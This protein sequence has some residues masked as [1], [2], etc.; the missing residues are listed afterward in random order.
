MTNHPHR[1]R[2]DAPEPAPESV[3]PM[4]ELPPGLSQ[5]GHGPTAR[6]MEALPQMLFQAV[7][8]ALQQVQVT[9]APLPCATCFLARLQWGAS[10]AAE[11]REAERAYAAAVAEQEQ[12]DPQDRVA[13]DP[14]SFAPDSL[15]S[16][17]PLQGGTVMVGGT[18][19][20][21]QHIPGA[22]GMPGTSPL[23]IAQAH[24]TPGMLS[25]MTRGRAA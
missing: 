3:P 15:Q 5:N 10:H 13:L 22:P 20:C 4:T 9:T 18:L 21:A 12:K 11:F 23:L 19:Y 24:L 7:T 14:A 6:L 17:P 2:D 1:E 25:E 16:A 8:A